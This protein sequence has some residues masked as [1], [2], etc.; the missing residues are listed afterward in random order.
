MLVVPRLPLRPSRVAVLQL[1]CCSTFVVSPI[2]PSPCCLPAVE[3]VSFS[4]D[5]VRCTDDRTTHVHFVTVLPEHDGVVD[6]DQTASLSASVV[7]ATGATQFEGASH[8]VSAMCVLGRGLCPTPPPLPYHTTP[9]RT[10]PPPASYFTP[11]HFAPHHTTSHCTPQGLSTPFCVSVHH[12]M[13]HHAT[14]PRAAPDRTAHN[15]PPPTHPAL[16]FSPHL[17]PPGA[18]SRP[19]TLPCLWGL[20]LATR[21]RSWVWTFPGKLWCSLFRRLLHGC[22]HRIENTDEPALQILGAAG[23]P[24]ARLSVF[25]LIPEGGFF[26]VTGV[27]GAAM[28]SNVV[29]R[30]SS[31]DS[32][33]PFTLE[34]RAHFFQARP[35]LPHTVF[36]LPTLPPPP[37][38]HTSPFVSLF[39]RSACMGTTQVSLAAPHHNVLLA[40]Y[41][42]LWGTSQPT[43]IT[44]TPEDCCGPSASNKV[45]VIPGNVDSTNEFTVVVSV[46]AASDAAFVG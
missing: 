35:V 46:T 14:P 4:P 9:H 37:H 15:C 22:S 25:E 13:P 2:P 27:P 42:L 20:W 44:L 28:A 21:L 8:E 45:T 7:G 31:S 36:P 6:S 17:P 23:E 26:Y 38:T 29:V 11:L 16:T 18:C 39:L 32:D 41:E 33:A 12:I 34:V 40:V 19:R 24:I 3:G 43:T 1:C 10:A 5:V 30:L